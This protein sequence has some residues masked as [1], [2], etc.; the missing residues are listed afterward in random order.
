MIGKM[1]VS[2]GK[3]D[4]KRNRWEEANGFLKLSKCKVL[5][6]KLEKNKLTIAWKYKFRAAMKM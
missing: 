4:K 6:L 3:E 5:A 1:V 2:K